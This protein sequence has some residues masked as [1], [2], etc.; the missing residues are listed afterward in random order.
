MA[1]NIKLASFYVM[2]KAASAFLGP[3][4]KWLQI[5]VYAEVPQVW[6]AAGKVPANPLHNSNISRCCL[7]FSYLRQ[8][9]PS[10]FACQLGVA[11]KWPQGW[12]MYRSL[13]SAIQ[14]WMHTA[15]IAACR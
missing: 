4:S 12:S 2:Q 13:Q 8:F 10:F 1:P 6:G 7:G 3:Q 9:F 5:E 15:V 11:T 14:V